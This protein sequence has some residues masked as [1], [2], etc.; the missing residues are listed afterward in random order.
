[1]TELDR[2]E[3]LQSTYSTYSTYVYHDHKCLITS[4]HI[5]LMMSYI[6]VLRNTLK[7]SNM[8]EVVRMLTSIDQRYDECRRQSSYY[9]YN[10]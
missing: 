8:P 1:M 4:H 5:M 10:H 7:N 3:F 2:F 6:Q 9:R